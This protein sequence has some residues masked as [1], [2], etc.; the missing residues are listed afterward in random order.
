[1]ENTSSPVGSVM[2]GGATTMHIAYRLSFPVNS[3]DSKGLSRW[4]VGLGER[5]TASDSIDPSKVLRM[6]K[7]FLL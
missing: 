2:C 6:G 1:M 4:P 7:P 3:I 5:V